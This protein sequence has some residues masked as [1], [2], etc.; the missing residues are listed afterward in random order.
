MGRL[1]LCLFTFEQIRVRDLV[2]AAALVVRSVRLLD[3]RSLLAK[4]VS[5]TVAE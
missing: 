4:A 2:S 1:N 5:L 3:R